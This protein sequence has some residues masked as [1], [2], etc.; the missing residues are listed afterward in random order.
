MRF[1]EPELGYTS[2]PERKN[3][4][5]SITEQSDIINSQI[6][7]NDQETPAIEKTT[8][9]NSRP[10]GE[11]GPPK[12]LK[13][14]YLSASIEYA[15]TAV[16]C[17]LNT[18]EEAVHS[19]DAEK[20]IVAMDNE[21]NNL[22]DNKTWEFTPLPDKHSESKGRWVYTLKQGKEPSKIQYKA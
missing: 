19:K 20:W 8:Q 6:G 15:Y 7:E 22:M 4:E 3:H 10:Q 1:L 17:I 9:P 14:Y 18:Y 13:D 11:A 12:H 21:I 5:E 16:P 2:I